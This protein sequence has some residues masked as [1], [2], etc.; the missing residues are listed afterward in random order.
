MKSNN[1]KACPPGVFLC[2]HNKALGCMSEPQPPVCA[3][4][5]RG[6]VEGLGSSLQREQGQPV[7]SASWLGEDILPRKSLPCF[8]PDHQQPERCGREARRGLDLPSV[9]VH[10][11]ALSCPLLP[12]WS[13]DPCAPAFCLHPF[14]VPILPT[15][16]QRSSLGPGV[17][18]TTPRRRSGIGTSGHPGPVLA[19]PSSGEGIPLGWECG[20][21]RGWVCTCVLKLLAPVMAGFFLHTGSG[22]CPVGLP[23]APAS[24]RAAG[25]AMHRFL[26]GVKM[27]PWELGTPRFGS[28]A[29]PPPLTGD[30]RAASRGDT[31]THPSRGPPCLRAGARQEGG[32]CH[33]NCIPPNYPRQVLTES[34]LPRCRRTARL[35][36][37]GQVRRLGAVLAGCPGVPMKSQGLGAPV[38]TLPHQL[39]C[40]HLSCRLRGLFSLQLAPRGVKPRPPQAPQASAVSPPITP[41]PWATTRRGFTS[42]LS[43]PRAGMREEHFSAL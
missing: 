36:H 3:A 34:P 27:P 13:T 32:K 35:S 29:L 26:P 7:P 11:P 38:P 15:P 12:T 25:A 1:K 2:L 28:R 8:P 17:T 43:L 5:G 9:E 6:A 40:G 20:W 16:S 42:P 33:H 30:P 21:E 22:T 10:P 39:T 41:L 19:Q 14:P 4:A 31:Q 18:T 37:P 23:R 24:S